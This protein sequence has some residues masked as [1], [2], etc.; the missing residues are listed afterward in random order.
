MNVSK[1]HPLTP[2]LY[3]FSP[4]THILP[5]HHVTHITYPPDTFNNPSHSQQ[6]T[7]T[8]LKITIV[9]NNKKRVTYSLKATAH[10]SNTPS[11]VSRLIL[12]AR[13]NRRST[14]IN[15]TSVEIT[16][17]FAPTVLQKTSQNHCHG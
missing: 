9:F 12:I 11:H 14:S 1:I 7:T 16:N 8:D 13:Y 15:N 17:K 5:E 6:Y 10:T 3:P 2:L 4:P